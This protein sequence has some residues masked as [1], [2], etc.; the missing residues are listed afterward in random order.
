MAVTSIVN[1][2]DYDGDD[3]TTVFAYGQPIQSEED[4]QIIKTDADGTQTTL[5]L[6]TDYSVAGSGARKARTGL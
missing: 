5:V 3:S 1:H 6:D 4:L 2:W